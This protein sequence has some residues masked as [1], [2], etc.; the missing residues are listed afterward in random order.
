MSKTQDQIISFRYSVSSC[1]ETSWNTD[2]IL[3]CLVSS[4]FQKNLHQSGVIVNY[5]KVK[6]SSASLMNFKG[7]R[8]SQLPW[9]KLR[10]E[11]EDSL[12]RCSARS[13]LLPAWWQTLLFRGPRSKLLKAVVWNRT[14]ESKPKKSISCPVEAM[15]GSFTRRAALALFLTFTSVMMFTVSQPGGIH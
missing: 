7:Q 10:Y 13:H 4:S 5:S 15:S 1:P 9:T 11:N 2:M 14:T 3:N 8:L 6:S 12:S